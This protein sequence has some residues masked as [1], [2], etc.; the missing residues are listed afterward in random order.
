MTKKNKMPTH[1][2]LQKCLDDYKEKISDEFGDKR[3]SIWPLY[4]C[5]MGILRLGALDFFD[6]DVKVFASSSSNIQGRWLIISDCIKEICP[7]D[8]ELKGYH[9]IIEMV[10][11][12]S[13]DVR[14]D[15]AFSPP[16]NR[17]NEIYNMAIPFHNWLLK[18]GKNFTTYK[19]E[20]KL[21]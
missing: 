1:E 11:K 16:I 21:G 14:H 19:K 4:D 6:L 2:D 10:N 9:G 7:D 12:F 8:S 13:N 17:L 18:Q 3:R 5:Y 20:K 15:D